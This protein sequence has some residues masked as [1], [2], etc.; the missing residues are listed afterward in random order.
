MFDI[1]NETKNIEAINHQRQLAGEVI[2]G[3]LFHGFHMTDAE[4]RFV[5]R[6][7]RV[8]RPLDEL[9]LACLRGLNA[10]RWAERKN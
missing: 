8:M 1:I 2:A 7:N 5:N 6:C 4:E 9:T 10:R 3:K